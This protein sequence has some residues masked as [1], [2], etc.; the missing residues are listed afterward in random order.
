MSVPL[1][2]HCNPFVYVRFSLEA[3]EAASDEDSVA[4][5]GTQEAEGTEC[6]ACVFLLMIAH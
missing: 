6:V 5:A 2:R 4:R 1:L 3:S